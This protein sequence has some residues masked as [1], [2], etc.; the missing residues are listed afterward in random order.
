MKPDCTHCRERFS[1]YLDGLLAAPERAE[2]DAHLSACPDCRREMERWRATLDTVG[3]L[4][5]P[6]A[7]EGFRAR[8]MAQLPLDAAPSEEAEPERRERP[9]LLTLYLRALP[10]AAMLLIVFGVVAIVQRNE[11]RGPRRGIH[12]P[13]APAAQSTSLA[14]A[15]SAPAAAVEQAAPPPAAAPAAPA[16]HLAAA[17]AESMGGQGGAASY[18]NRAELAYRYAA[19]RRDEDRKEV[20]GRMVPQLEAKARASGF[21]ATDALKDMSGRQKKGTML[22]MEE[23]TAGGE[24]V[25]RQTRSLPLAVE[26]PEQVLTMYAA[27]P[28][29]LIRRAVEV[30]NRQGLEVTLVFKPGGRADISIQVPAARYDKLVAALS[31]LTAPQSQTLSNSAIAQGAF[32]R[33]ALDD[34]N[35]SN[36][37]RQK[38]QV[39]QQTRMAATG[40]M[41]LRERM[42]GPE[43]AA[44]SEAAPA[45]GASATGRAAASTGTPA[46]T[47]A[48]A[49]SVVAGAPLR[50][51]ANAPAPE[52]PRQAG[53][54]GNSAQDQAGAEA[55]PSVVNLQIT[56]QRPPTRRPATPLP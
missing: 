4:P 32:F 39:E 38:Q 9:R 11:A 55:P 37:L 24:L 22:D 15:R 41:G 28:A 25:F 34:Y 44:Q 1:D 14:R 33:K 27:D 42:Q 47:A 5:R 54:E 29:D 16:R 46:A 20:A 17:P 2:M 3:G 26:R 18:G 56:I 53:E 49:P 51:A 6:A 8:V 19:P 45:G 40:V 12:A 43:V 36:N 21:A 13:V 50:P 30:A 10:V 48:P 52:K 23:R 7:P 31:N 35:A